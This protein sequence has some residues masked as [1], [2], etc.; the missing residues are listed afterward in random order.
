MVRG[1]ISQCT[2]WVPYFGYGKWHERKLIGNW[3]EEAAT[4]SVWYCQP[5]SSAYIAHTHAYTATTT[6]HTY[7]T[8]T[9]YSNARYFHS[10]SCQTIWYRIYKYKLRT[11]KHHIQIYMLEY[12]PLSLFLPLS[13]YHILVVSLTLWLSFR[14]YFIYIL[15]STP[16]TATSILSIA[17][18]DILF[19]YRPEL[20][21]NNL[22]SMAVAIPLNRSDGAK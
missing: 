20:Y 15:P 14:L 22:H 5:S 1:A 3:K 12:L 18:S 4:N 19:I 10:H 11:Y 8:N 9:M 7:T 2:T 6:T 21:N 17:W 16:S 13:L